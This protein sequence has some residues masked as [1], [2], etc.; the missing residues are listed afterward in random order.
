MAFSLQLYLQLPNM[1]LA[2]AFR[3]FYTLCMS[4]SVQRH[5]SLR[6]LLK[7]W[8]CCQRA[9]Y[10][11]SKQWNFPN[12]S[13]AP[14]IVE[15][16][17][18]LQRELHTSVRP[19]STVVVCWQRKL[20]F[21]R[22]QQQPPTRPFVRKVCQNKRIVLARLYFYTGLSTERARIPSAAFARQWPVWMTLSS[23]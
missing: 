7:R 11:T 5:S 16:L 4:A 9:D 15:L 2:I 22:A 18:Q 8:S 10:C 6:T 21:A 13:N 23:R 12:S 1:Y 20:Q 14:P 17:R 3:G 19:T